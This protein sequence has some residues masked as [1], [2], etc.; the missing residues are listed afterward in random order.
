[1]IHIKIDDT[2]VDIVDKME[3]EKSWEIILDFPLW[4]PILHNYISLKIIKSKA[5]DK[6]LIIATSDK[7]GKK[8]W[9]QIGIEYSV[10]KS[11]GFI[12]KAST[13]SLLGHNYTFWEYLKFQISWY[14]SEFFSNIQTHKKFHT[15]WKYSRA[16]YE[17]TWVT[18]FML[19]LI[20]SLTVFLFIYY[21]AI[22]KSYIDIKPEIAIRKEAFNFIFIQDI[23]DTILWNNRYIKIEQ[24][25]KTLYSSDTFSA[26]EI[27]ESNNIATWEVEIYNNLDEQQTLVPNTRLI[28]SDWLIFRTENWINIPA[29]TRDNFWNISPWFAT[30]KARSEV[31]DSSWSYIWDKWNI[32]VDIDLLLPGLDE[33]LQNEIYWKTTTVFTWWTND[34]QKIISQNDIDRAKELFTKKLESEV[35]ISIKNNILSN[36]NQN[37]TSID[38]LPWVDS[39]QYSDLEINIEEWVEAWVLKESFKLEWSITSSAYTYNKETVIQKL[40]TLLNEKKLEGVEKI[41]YIDENSLRMSEIIYI[42]T[43][44]FSMKSTFEMEAVYVHDFLHKNNSFTDSLK[45]QIRWMPKQEAESYL[46]N[47]PKIS[48]VK[49][50]LRPFFSKNVSNIY[51]NIIFNI[52]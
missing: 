50:T 6:K 34:F 17:K 4:H 30:V 46:L 41:S 36:N 21:F 38:I 15:L 31:K 24:V 14:K 10:I 16:S 42:N 22:S 23:P 49:I 29:A 25:T 39:I 48:N 47:N 11:K 3:L 27:L 52:E 20:T 28:T 26:T 13:E 5:K 18:L 32:W 19:W 2:I 12:E 33:D 37:N 8:I 44:P 40:K 45:Q 7:I 43:S 35:I 9:K 1:M 51:N